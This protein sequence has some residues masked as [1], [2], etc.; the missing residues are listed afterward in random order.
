MRSPRVIP[1]VSVVAVFWSAA[2]AD[3]QFIQADVYDA[4]YQAYVE[5]DSDFSQS[6]TEFISEKLEH[7]AGQITIG[8][9]DK[10]LRYNI[11]VANKEIAEKS[12]ERESLVAEIIGPRDPSE[13]RSEDRSDQDN[14]THQK[15]RDIDAFL[16]EQRQYVEVHE[17]ILEKISLGT[18]API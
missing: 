11:G 17:C 1:A 15:V 2:P 9:L 5:C 4:L 7:D 8:S 18:T 12:A 3:E 13:D 6:R 14:E 16:K 10:I